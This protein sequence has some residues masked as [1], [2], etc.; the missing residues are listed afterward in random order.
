[1]NSEL[2]RHAP[3]HVHTEF[4][5]L[6]GASRLADICKKAAAEKMPALAIS[7][8]GTMYG[9]F[10]F[11]HEAKKNDV[12]P[13]I[14]CEVYVINGDHTLKGKEHRHK[15]Y[16][17]VLLAKN[18]T[19]Y[20][21][22]VKIVSEAC[23]NGFYYKPRIDKEYVRNHS[24]GLIALSACLGG[25]VNNLLL[26]NQDEEAR[27]AALEYKN[28]FGEDFYLEIQDHNYPE[29]RHVN[30][31]VIALAKELGIKVVAT[32]DSHY[33]NPGD[34]IAHDA[35]LCLQMQKYIADF[36]RMHF[37][38]TEHLKTEEEM[39]S[40][41]A[42]HL[43]PEDIRKAV[44]ENSEEIV[45]KIED[46]QIMNKPPNHMPDPRVP[47][48]YNF[49]T[50][51]RKITYDGAVHRFGDL[52]KLDPHYKKEITERL[53][54]ELEIMNGSGFPSYFIVVW[55]FMKWAREHDIPVGP[56]RGSAAGSLVAYC[57]GIT[58]ID[59]LKYDLLFER[60]LN[61]ERK[62]MPDID[63]DFCIERREEVINYVREKYGEENVCQ[64]ITFNRLTS[65]SVIK[66]M[67][68]VL[69]YPYTKA[70][71][72]AKMI[73][74]VRGKP[75]SIS[76][77]L[78]NHNE[79]AAKYKQDPEAKQ[80][81]D[82]AMKN[83]GINK[84][85]GVHAAGVII[86]D[87]PI[88]E[89]IP[90]TRN[91]DGSIITQFAMEEC[92]EMGLIK[93]DFLGLRNLTMIKK[94]LDIIEENGG[95]KIDIDEIPLD[96]EATYDTVCSGNLSGIF[97]LETS[98]GMRQIARDLAPRNMEDIS[99]LIALYRPG[100]LD[101]GMIDDFIARKSGKQ[102]IT[103]EHPLLEGILDNTYG[104]IVYQEQIMQIA[105]VLA[106][107]SLGEADL[108][109]RAMG[110]KKPE[111][112]L[113]F[114]DKFLK[115]CDENKIPTSVGEKLFEQMIAFAEYCFNKSHSTAYGMVTYQTAYLKTHYPVEY[116]T[117]L[118]K[119]CA[120]ETDRIKSYLVEAQRLGI[121]VVAPDINCSEID[122]TADV[123]NKQIFFGLSAVK[124]V[125]TNPC[126]SILEE[127]E[128]GG[129]FKN[130]FDFCQ[131]IDHKQVN[132]KT[133]ENLIRC[134]AFDKLPEKAGRK[135]MIENM[136]S[137]IDAAKRKQSQ[138]SKG[139]SSLFE[140]AGTDLSFDIKPNYLHG[141]DD[142]YPE[143][144][145]QAMEYQLLGLFVNNHPMESVQ[146]LCQ[147]VAKHKIKDL[148]TAKDQSKVSVAALVTD[149]QKKIT[150]SKKIIAIAQVEDLEGRV[151]AVLFS[152]KLEAHEHLLEKGK[153]VLIEATLS[154]HSEGDKSLLV[155]SMKDLDELS[156][157]EYELNLDLCDDLYQ[158]LH[159]IKSFLLKPEMKGDSTIILRL[160]EGDDV[161]R[162]SLGGK[163]TM[164][165][166][167]FSKKAFEKLLREIES[168]TDQRIK[169]AAK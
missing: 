97:Q 164:A 129:E 103:Y 52:D 30:P 104:T 121:K 143:R 96:D 39:L 23:V 40:L 4:S 117:S 125:G 120:G 135:A 136:D 26:N 22:L 163:F 113:P 100:P 69:E 130:F 67:A 133:V 144:E 68:R 107:F 140:A 161:Q 64:I 98:S 74:V 31:K 63:T 89:V 14:G 20:K 62:S 131:R 35:L 17:L 32:N 9:V 82:L 46:Y 160:K 60:F 99:A 24:E 111:V 137:F 158:S 77:M 18:D 48:G 168:K 146:E 109:R 73:P 87:V 59:P 10:N 44:L 47:E 139:Q 91:N 5:L 101:T 12:K 118:F 25:E 123:A 128:N 132:K 142:E 76:W 94:A 127:R 37:S 92:A 152:N 45:N 50:Y 51:L 114:K 166:N 1:M 7:D 79:F 42:D 55:D 151:E 56:G 112:L 138:A 11:Y 19:G 65:R 169:I 15:L 27:A 150:K 93:M 153:R 165:N 119:S 116:L 102:K 16:H 156:S 134:G 3:L 154:K 8:H 126:A 159:Q 88:T 58:N 80:V 71:E 122:F 13:I 38:G 148:D 6:D 54:R 90:V 2:K 105:Q 57:L 83:E 86:S 157:L 43:D 110:K 28:I 162:L 66:D 75:R 106:G 115:G 72:L 124:G 78:E 108:L 34:A 36:P 81:I 61:P 155:D 84:T 70:E 53:D 33:T 41:F 149:F 167:D 145:T 95:G 21:N 85:F 49:E 147:I 29:D 141:A